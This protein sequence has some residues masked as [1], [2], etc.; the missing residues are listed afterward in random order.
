MP[1]TAFSTALGWMAIS[2]NSRGAALQRLVFGLPS[3]SAAWEALLGSAAHAPAGD[4]VSLSSLSRLV[5]S[6][7][8]LAEGIPQD[9]SRIEVDLATRSPF[10]R[11]ILHACQQIPWGTTWTYSE[12][13]ESCGYLRGARAVGNVMASNPLPL[14]IPCHRV[15]AADGRLGGFSAPQGT[16][17]K[18]RLLSMEGVNCTR[19]S[20]VKL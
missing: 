11:R 4:S 20:R 17:M 12:L 9:F 18:R 8:A 2:C 15:V 1:A 5:D 16:L 6:L 3:N 19:L 14:I 10:Q 13:A 7:Q